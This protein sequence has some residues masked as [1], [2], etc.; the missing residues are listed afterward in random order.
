[1]S[2]SFGVD[3]GKGVLAKRLTVRGMLI[4]AFLAFAAP[5]VASDDPSFVLSAGLGNLPGYFPGYLGN[6]FITRA[7]ICPVPR[8][9]RAGMELIS[10]PVRPVPIGHG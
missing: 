10:A 6:G 9:F 3:G 8:S 2:T 5:V 1:V 4:A 7:A